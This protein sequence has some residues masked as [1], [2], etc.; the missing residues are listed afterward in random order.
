MKQLC[1]YFCE[2]NQA[3]ILVTFH[4]FKSKKDWANAWPS[5]CSLYLY[6]KTLF[7]FEVM[8][9]CRHTCWTLLCILHYNSTPWCVIASV[10]MCR[11]INSKSLLIFT[12]WQMAAEGQSD[13]MASDMEVCMKQRCVI[14]FLHAEKNGTHWHSLI[15]LLSIYRDQTVG[16]STVRWWVACFCSGNSDM[17]DKPNSRRPCRFLGAQH[18][19]SF[20]LQ[21]IIHS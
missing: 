21:V 1:N 2:R 6:M 4:R 8:Y 13:K 7:L 9:V 12:M 11:L 14:E 15:S 5:I 19:S 10:C 3:L 16:V 20:S 17:K 18:A